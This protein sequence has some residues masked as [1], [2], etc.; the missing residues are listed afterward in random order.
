LKLCQQ[1]MDRP[2]LQRVLA[3]VETMGG[4]TAI[5]SDKTGTLTENRMTV[6]AGW[7]PSKLQ[8]LA[9]S[10]EDLSPALA[11]EFEMNC[12][13]NSKVRVQSLFTIT[14]VHRSGLA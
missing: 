3:A 2:I 12:A 1:K 8:F 11:E 9:P 13:L 10:R 4:A 5:C 7:F 6:V 14:P